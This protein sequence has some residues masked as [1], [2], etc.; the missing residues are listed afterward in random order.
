[1]ATVLAARAPAT[2]DQRSGNSGNGVVLLHPNPIEPVNIA[3]VQS[4]DGDSSSD[5]TVPSTGSSATD[6][7]TPGSLLSAPQGDDGV[8]SDL[9]RYIAVGCLHF[10]QPYAFK[11][12]N[13]HTIPEW[14]ELFFSNLPDEL[15]LIIGSHASSLLQ[16]RWIRLFLHQ[17]TAKPLPNTLIRF[18]LLPEDWGRRSIDRQ[19]RSLKT[20]LRELLSQVDTSPEAWAGNHSTTNIQLFDPWASAEN[21]SLFYLF[22]RLPSPAP[23][24]D[25]V[26]NR[27][28]RNAVLGLLEAASSGYIDDE[29]IPGLKTKLYPYQA[30]SAALMVQREAAPQLQLDPRLEVRQSPAGETYFFGARDG[31]FLREPRYYDS[32]RGGVLAETMGLGKTIISLAVILATKG[33]M[34]L[35]PPA[36]QPAPPVRKRVGS[37]A[38]MAASNIGR[39]AV[40][41]KAF[42]ENLEAA[43]GIDL[44]RCKQAL[45]ENMPYYEIPPEIPRMNRTT[46]IP[47]PRQLVM[48]S[49]TIIVVPR[50]LLHQW[51]SEIQKHVVPGSLKVLVMDSAS[52][53]D[54]KS[55]RME[56]EGI[57]VLNSLPPPTELMKYDIIIF[58]RNRFEQEIQD[59]QDEKGRRFAAGVPR[60]CECAY[61]GATRLRDCNCLTEV[62]E[63]PLKK[64][65]FLRIIIDEGHNFS[66]GTSNAVLVA[67]QIKAERRWVVSGTPAKNLVGVELDLFTQDGNEADPT[68]LRELAMEQRK[69][70]SLDDEDNTK[71]A[72]ALGSLASHF[73]M[74]QPWYSS[75]SEDRL[76][77]DDYIYRHEHQYKKTYSGFSSCF[78]RVLEGLVVKTRPEDVERDIQLPPMRH[79]TVYLKPCWYDKMTA[80]LFVQ[81]LRANAIT[82]ERSGVDY[83]F[84]SS[85]TQAR[86][87]LIRNLRQSNFTWTGFSP[88]DI[89]SSLETTSKYLGKKEKNCT[90][91][92]AKLLLESSSIVAELLKS[93]GWVALS[94]AHEIGLAVE[95][96]PAESE[97]LFALAYKN[98]AMIGLTQL[99]DGQSHVD[100]QILQENPA[101]GLDIVGRMA[102]ANLQALQEVEKTTIK[103]EVDERGHHGMPK[104]AVPSSCVGDQPLTSKTKLAVST[105]ARPRKSPTKKI[106]KR[107]V[108]GLSTPENG[109]IQEL[110]TIKLFTPKRAGDAQPNGPFTS[111]AASR[112]DPT[113]ASTNSIT[114]PS[115]PKKRKL[116]LTDELA[117][118]P[119]TSP[120]LRTRIL[121]TTSSKLTYLISTVL[122][123]HLTS[124]ILIFY[125]GDNAAYCIAQMLELLYINHRIYARQLDNIKRAQYVKL[126]NEDPDVRVLLIDVACGALGLNLNVASVVLIV[127]PINRPSIEAQA[128]KRAHRIGQ[129]KEVL[130]ETLVLEGTIEEAIFKRAK[131]MSRGEHLEAKELEDDN[132]IVNILQNAEVLPIEPGEGEGLNQFALF[133]EPLQVFGRSGREKYHRFGQAEGK[134]ERPAAKR[135]RAK[136][137]AGKA[138]KGERKEVVDADTGMGSAGALQTLERSIFG[139]L[140][141]QQ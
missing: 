87:S 50:N 92:D 135:A 45:A 32:P 73:L 15:K 30:R 103:R 124:K 108:A 17:S 119:P 10:E 80:N 18:Y 21:V 20:A 90:L 27:Y 110:D 55:G 41:G 127:N 70:F 24:P 1:M 75:T 11:T 63:S 25:L 13:P 130:V 78:L 57:D 12:G 123:H 65:H 33:H 56:I 5:A 77:W 44:S 102:Q 139:G 81:V 76:E 115:R 138:K 36:Y 111:G 85:S 14:T 86:H 51:Q 117:T 94:K 2:C 128:I 106:L 93:E 43:E 28:S 125:D 83:L 29:P 107:P 16:A 84:H 104:A 137:D 95:D 49:T 113:P 6:V 116:T 99:I 3:A 134:G 114:T 98:P 97:H 40:P 59:G 91:E 121:G 8:L 23:S 37:L 66:S 132:Q 38:Q 136:G 67:K 26:K 31:S 126:F 35:I 105:K 9:S 52:R 47:P 69:N 48:C 60:H 96:W 118:L 22:N 100:Q 61:I 120:L 122:A 101:E 64:L 62:Y 46:R 89:V 79:R 112:L 53:R 58:T 133:E 54:S 131:Q 68:L 42:L 129:T 19:S 34:P 82:S 140:D 4:P 141:G 74:V 88:E 72:K 109:H 39:K 71:A 7:E